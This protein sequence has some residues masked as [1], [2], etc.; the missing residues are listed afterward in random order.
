MTRDWIFFRLICGFR[1]IEAAERGIPH[2]VRAS[3]GQLLVLPRECDRLL[4]SVDRS[5]TPPRPPYLSPPPTALERAERGLAH[6]Q[7]KP[8]IAL[9]PGSK[10]PAKKWFIER[11]AEVC[12]RIAATHP[13]LGIVI[14]GGP[15]DRND[16]ETLVEAVGRERAANLAGVTD[17][18][19]SAAAMK[20]CSLYLGNDTGTMHLAAIMGLPCVAV[21][22]SRDN[23]ETWSPWGNEHAIL[24]RDL[25]CSGCMLERCVREQMRCLDLIGVEDVWEA[26]A[27]RLALIARGA[28]SLRVLA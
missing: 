1:R 17:V 23:R 7:D 6:L 16:G 8:L 20:H 10:M 19:E 26:L 9:G 22:T 12:R 5:G 2:A 4:Q 18:I 14:F 15:E 3:D 28:R 25:P 21:F 24:R 13:N 11:Y 27:P